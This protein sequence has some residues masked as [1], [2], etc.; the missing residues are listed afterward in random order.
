[1]SSETSTSEKDILM[2]KRAKRNGYMKKYRAKRTEACIKCRNEANKRYYE[3]SRI[4]IQKYKE[5]VESEKIGILEVH[6]STN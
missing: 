1:M 6:S 2:L 3:K 4:M 5:I